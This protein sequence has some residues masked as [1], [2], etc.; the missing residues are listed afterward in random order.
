MGTINEFKGHFSRAVHAVLIATGGAKL[1]MAAER[2][3]FKFA[4][5][6]TAI[7]GA[8][9]R[10][11]PAAYYFINVFHDNGTGMK[12]IFNFFVVFFKNLL[13]DIHKTIMKE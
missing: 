7:H 13:E 10:R 4:A 11:I 6:G 5:A 3:K 1:R 12:D 9:I 2:D 8:A